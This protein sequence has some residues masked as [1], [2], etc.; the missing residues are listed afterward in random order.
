M[1]IFITII[2]SIC[3]IGIG[4]ALLVPRKAPH[5]LDN[6]PVNLILSRDLQSE[7]IAVSGRLKRDD[8][9]FDNTNVQKWINIDISKDSNDIKLSIANTIP[10]ELKSLTFNIILTGGAKKQVTIKIPEAVIDTDVVVQETPSPD[11]PDDDAG[12]ES[13]EQEPLAAQTE[14]ETVPDAETIEDAPDTVTIEEPKREEP[15]DKPQKEDTGTEDIDDSKLA[16]ETIEKTGPVTEI[17]NQPD[18]EVKT[19]PQ[20]QSEIINSHFDN[21]KDPATFKLANGKIV[22]GKSRGL[23]VPF[24]VYKGNISRRSPACVYEF[25]DEDPVAEIHALWDLGGRFLL[26]KNGTMLTLGGENRPIGPEIKDDIQKI[27]KPLVLE[28]NDNGKKILDV[29]CEAMGVPS[30]SLSIVLPEEVWSALYQTVDKVAVDNQ[31]KGKI[32]N[33]GTEIRWRLKNHADSYAIIIQ[34]SDMIKK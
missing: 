18:A 16:T 15:E 6:N 30:G 27:D 23:N 29:F 17:T 21:I 26:T 8:I 33:S 4:I 3:V 31:L 9:S 22:Y 2:L 1:K 10:E 34:K 24:Q 13:D 7:L 25:S 11:K 32:S 28:T 20:P 14:E 5:F 19:W 12:P